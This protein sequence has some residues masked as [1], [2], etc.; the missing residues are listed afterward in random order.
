MTERTTIAPAPPPVVEVHDPTVTPADV[1]QLMD[2]GAPVGAIVRLVA[3]VLDALII[4]IAIYLVALV[5]R[6][7][8]GPTLRITDVDGV[9]RVRVDRLRSVVDAVSATTVTGVYFVGSWL[10]FG[11]TPMQRLIG[12]QVERA[13]DGGRLRLRQ[14]IG[15]WLLLGASFGLISTLLVSERLLGAVLALAI[16]LWYAILFITTARDRRK[17]GLHDR[18]A[19]SVVRRRRHAT[20]GG[21]G[22]DRPQTA[23]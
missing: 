17:R 19:G 6:A 21:I 20:S 7:V 14:A 10:R 11:G 1:V 8:I 12:A 15:R 3:Y 9:Q 16:A 13:D 22:T 18:A 5:L 2:D 4:A 23:E